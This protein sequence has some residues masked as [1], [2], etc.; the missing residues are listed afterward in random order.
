MFYIIIFRITK[1]KCEIVRISEPIKGNYART[2]N[3]DLSQLMGDGPYK[4]KYRLDM[5]KW[6]EEVRNND[7][8]YFCKAA[9]ENGN[10]L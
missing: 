8:G 5:I 9:C 2:H 6:S 10:I 7:Y 4:E 3:L 1:E